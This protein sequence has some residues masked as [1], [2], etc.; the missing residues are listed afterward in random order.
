[1][2]YGKNQGTTMEKHAKSMIKSWIRHFSSEVSSNPTRLLHQKF[3]GEGQQKPRSKSTSIHEFNK[4]KKHLP[5]NPNVF[6]N[7]PN[8][9]KHPATIFKKTAKIRQVA[10]S[11]KWGA[12]PGSLV[13]AIALD[14]GVSR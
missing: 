9:L 13:R 11:P 14:S 4:K 5:K 2:S 8:I 10:G 1:M 6:K 3:R 7:P 12:T